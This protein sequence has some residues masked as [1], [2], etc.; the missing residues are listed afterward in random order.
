MMHIY[1]KFHVTFMNWCLG[2]ALDPSW[3]CWQIP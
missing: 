3:R 2:S 1:A